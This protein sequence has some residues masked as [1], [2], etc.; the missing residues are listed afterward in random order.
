M[1]LDELKEQITESIKVT[2]KLI[3]DIKALT[4]E[5]ESEGVW[6]I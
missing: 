1:E 6:W 5:I 4:A 2:E 3:E